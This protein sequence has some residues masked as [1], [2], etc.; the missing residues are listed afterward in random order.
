MHPSGHVLPTLLVDWEN[1]QLRPMFG[2]DYVLHGG[3]TS[4]TSSS[5][6]S[7]YFVNPLIDFR[8]IIT[9]G[10][11]RF[12][13]ECYYYRLSVSENY[14]R[15]TYFFLFIFCTI[16]QFC[17]FTGQNVFYPICILHKQIQNRNYFYK[18]SFSFNSILKK[19]N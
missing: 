2:A 6:M 4:P 19:Q 1:G 10:N 17:N 5:L 18:S 9:I 7:G 14:Y 13:R 8:D 3:G 11:R 12:S 15:Q 16:E